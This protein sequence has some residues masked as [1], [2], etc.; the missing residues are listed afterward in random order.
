MVAHELRTAATAL[1]L[2]RLK[3]V[4]QIQRIVSGARHQLNAQQVGL[5]LVFATVTKE[6]GAQTKLGALRDDLP[7]VAANDGSR[8]RAGN[9]A[10][11][12]GLLLVAPAVP[13][14]RITWL[15]SCAMTPA[16]SP[17]TPA[18]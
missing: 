11:L 8:N 17:S 12:E 1:F 5:L 9:G 6:V 16:T 13:C 10:N 15:S 18:A 2:D 14:R 3:H 7:D 4:H